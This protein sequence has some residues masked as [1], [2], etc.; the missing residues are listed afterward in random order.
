M[1]EYGRSLHDLWLVVIV[2]ISQILIER[3]DLLLLLQDVLKLLLRR[4]LMLMQV[5]EVFH[6]H[7]LLRLQLRHLM[8]VMLPS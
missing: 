4:G 6:V 2:D 8:I 5:L 3:C 1:L 7:L